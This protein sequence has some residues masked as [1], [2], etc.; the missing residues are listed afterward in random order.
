MSLPEEKRALRLFDPPLF[1]ALALVTATRL[2]FLDFVPIWDGR[3][4]WDDCLAP[5][6]AAPF[7]PLRLNCFG[8]P[9]MAYMSIVSAGERLAPGN[10]WLLN[11]ANLL[12]SLLATAAFHSIVL[13]LWPKMRGTIEAFLATSLFAVW[14]AVAAASINL[15]P[16]HGVL[17]FFLA[18]VAAL[19]HRNLPLAA[20]SGL[21]LVFSKEPGLLLYP[22]ATAVH[23]LVDVWLEPGP[24]G[25]R[26]RRT[27]LRWP[28]AVPALAFA[29]YAGATVASGRN[30]LWAARGSTAGM[31]GTFT[32]FDPT[33]RLFL[34]YLAGVALVGFSW[35]PS[36]FV[37]GALADRLLRRALD[38]PRSGSEPPDRSAATTL[39]LV[40]LLASF[41]LTRYR[42]F[43]NLRYVAVLCPLLALAFVASLRSLFPSRPLRLLLG[44]ATSALLL[45][46]CFRTVD[47]L[48]KRW[49]GTFRFG[50]HEMLRMTSR[51]GECCG[52]GRDQLLYNFEALRFHY[53]Q[54][55]IWERL[56]PGPKSVVASHDDADYYLQGPLDPTTFRRTLRQEGAITPGSASREI[57]LRVGRLPRELH[58]IEYPN[59]DQTEPLA[60]FAR[61]YETVER[62][63][64]GSDG[65]WIPVDRLRIRPELAASRAGSR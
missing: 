3:N 16:D 2:P 47:P 64:V 14:P 18:Y 36:L 15:N 42:T 56:R 8:H 22:A 39:V 65:Y 35:I 44:A 30:L 34:A 51:T 37:A 61:Y 12:L 38:R 54:N 32:S 46:S 17:V 52:Y 48:S 63:L 41:L 57:L 29:A 27:L 43:A 9:S 26:V 4:Y 40:G 58:F 59:F 10:E 21:L 49:Y 20:A 50:D 23:L 13:A 28:L 45:V 7:D 31:V 19:L 33:D 24:G 1:G 11:L 53:T 25:R 55:E 62:E 5:A 6:L 60:W